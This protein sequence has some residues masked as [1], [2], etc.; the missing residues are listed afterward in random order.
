MHDVETGA[1]DAL[2]VWGP[3]G[4]YFAKKA[5]P[6]LVV[7]PLHAE[8]RPPLAY[9]IA[10]GL[11]RNEL[12]WKHRLNDVIRARKADFE[13]V[14]RDYG[15]PLVPIEAAPIGGQRPCGGGVNDGS[16]AGSGFP[17]DA[18]ANAPAPHAPHAGRG[19]RS[20]PA[21]KRLSLLLLLAMAWARSPRRPSRRPTGST[22]IWRR[23]RHAE[24]P[25]RA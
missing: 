21:P 5:Q 10:F 23:S 13:A 25:A 11:R 22:I 15:V 18:D 20:R 14:L 16:A 17:D 7:S 8:Q 2:V 12:E 3:I 1:I 9:R 19:S 6:A 4:G 24:R